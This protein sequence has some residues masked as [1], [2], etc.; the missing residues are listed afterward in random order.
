MTPAG[1]TV[2]RL[3]LATAVAAALLAGGGLLWDVLAPP[4]ANNAGV[5]VGGVVGTIT[6]TAVLVVL[7]VYLYRKSEAY[8]D[9]AQF[10]PEA[11]SRGH[12]EEI[13][14]ATREHAVADP[15]EKATTYRELTDEQLVSVYESIDR[16][17]VPA[18]FDELVLE[19]RRRTAKRARAR[20]RS[21]A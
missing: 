12:L 13:A 11:L 17:R 9:P 2:A 4:P 14:A 10:A 8:A 19:V 7:A 5:R 21:A 6:R 3:A 20:R 16:E 1:P 18:R 15:S